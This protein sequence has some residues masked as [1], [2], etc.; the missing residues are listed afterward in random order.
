M[1]I[2]FLME[3]HKS[4][5]H[6]LHFAAAVCCCSGGRLEVQESDPEEPAATAW[7]CGIIQHRS[8]VRSLSPVINGY[9]K[10]TM[11]GPKEYL[12]C[13][14]ILYL[15][16]SVHEMGRNY[17]ILS[18]IFKSSF[19]AKWHPSILSLKLYIKL[20]SFAWWIQ[21]VDIDMMH[22]KREESWNIDLSFRSQISL[23]TLSLN[24]FL[25]KHDCSLTSSTVSS[26]PDQLL[27]SVLFLNLC[28]TVLLCIKCTLL[29]VSEKNCIHANCFHLLSISLKPV[30]TEF[31]IQ[32]IDQLL[33]FVFLYVSW[34][35]TGDSNCIAT[36]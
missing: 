7:H 8:P 16:S 6:S 22:L 33:C 1:V 34:N 13:F 2:A 23:T 12:K 9:L 28:S 26:K 27:T 24:A 29:N 17:G 30:E 36:M 3:S 19:F 31:V 10:T 5:D 11:Y 4:A 21:P 14:E 25:H 32:F 20:K 35:L 18:L 15:W